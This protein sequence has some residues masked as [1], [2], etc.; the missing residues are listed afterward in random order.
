ME[1]PRLLS[2]RGDGSVIDAP[3]CGST[4]LHWACANGRVED[5]EALLAAGRGVGARD[6]G[7][8]T[9]LH[10]A[11]LKGRGAVARALLDAGADAG[12][13]DDSGRTA[14]MA[15]RRR[16]GVGRAAGRSGSAAPTPRAQV[17]PHGDARA[18]RPRRDALMWAADR[19]PRGTR[20]GGGRDPGARAGGGAAAVEAL[21]A[22]SAPGAVDDAAL[23]GA[24]APR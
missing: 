17:L 2:P 18:R 12:A 24:G 4:S 6:G 1:S 23:A 10:W 13:A 22:A 7:G 8:R 19:A 3:G 16:A 5:V 20:A 14:L 9:P 15:A 21:L 11:V